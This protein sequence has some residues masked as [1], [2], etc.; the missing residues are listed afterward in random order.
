MPA[1][2]YEKRRENVRIASAGENRRKCKY[3]IK[4]LNFAGTS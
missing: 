2:E 3:I 4:Y 1:A